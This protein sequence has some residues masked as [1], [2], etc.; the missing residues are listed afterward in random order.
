MTIALRYRD[1]YYIA[2]YDS[3]AIAITIHYDEREPLIR[4][5]NKELFPCEGRSPKS[6]TNSRS[7]ACFTSSPE[8]R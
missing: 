5:G 7:G 1:M 8:L 2:V 3:S 6:A 4:C